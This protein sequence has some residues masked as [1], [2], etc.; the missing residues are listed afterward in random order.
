MKTVSHTEQEARLIAAQLGREPREPWAVLSRCWYGHPNA[1]VSPP[2][3][4]DGTPFPTW[5]WLSCPHLADAVS[6]EES[7]GAAKRWAKR[8]EEEPQLA[9]QVL[10]ADAEL[11]SLRAESGHDPHPEVGIAGQADPLA[12][13]CLHAHVAL[14]L[15]GIADP[16]GLDVLAAAGRRCQD[17]RCAELVRT[18]TGE[19]HQGGGE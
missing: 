16:I 7:S 15:A 4:Q 18:L 10:A 8:L 11:R 2:V 13:K 3:L 1:I 9:E 19:Q 5:A 6:A 14:A 17:H 12:T